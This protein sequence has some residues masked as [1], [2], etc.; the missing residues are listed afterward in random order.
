M[1]HLGGKYPALRCNEKRGDRKAVIRQLNE[2]SVN[3]LYLLQKAKLDQFIVKRSSVRQASIKPSPE[4]L[5]SFLSKRSAFSRGGSVGG[6]FQRRTVDLCPV[7]SFEDWLS[8]S[9]AFVSTSIAD[10]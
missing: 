9:A 1:S 3:F 7:S 2:I 10:R 5:S 4:R 6:Y 8:A